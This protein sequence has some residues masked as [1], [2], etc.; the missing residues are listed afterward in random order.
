M[1][2]AFVLSL[3]YLAQSV[4][5]IKSLEVMKITKEVALC[6]F[7]PWGGACCRFDQLTKEELEELEEMVNVLYPDGIAKTALNDLFWFDFYAVCAWLCLD[8]D[9]ETDEVIRQ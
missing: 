6:D 4:K 2:I 9:E 7:K 1:A 3:F 8:Y 5:Q